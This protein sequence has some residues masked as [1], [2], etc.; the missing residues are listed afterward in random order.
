M[1]KKY[2][3]VLQR[4]ES[5]SRSVLGSEAGSDATAVFHTVRPSEMNLIPGTALASDCLAFMSRMGSMRNLRLMASCQGVRLATCGVLWS[6]G[7]G[8]AA[9]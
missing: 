1:E 2:H 4:P 9:R 5:L 3:A 8:L 6:T 7:D